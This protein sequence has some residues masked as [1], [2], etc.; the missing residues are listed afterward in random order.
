MS[1]AARDALKAALAIAAPGLAAVRGL[2][3]GGSFG[4]GIAD[5]W[6]D[7]DYVA[8][9]ASDDAAGLVDDWV[10][11][12]SAQAPIVHRMQRVFPTSALVNLITADWVRCDLL[13]ETE[14]R[15]TARAQDRL[16][17]VFERDQLYAALPVKTTL[18]PV[19]T[20]ALT[21]AVEEFL[22]VLGLSHLAVHRDDPFTAQWG[23]AL[24]RD[25]MRVFVL[26]LE[27]AAGLSGALTLARELPEARMALL[28]DLPVGGADLAAALDAQEELA[29]R[30][31]PLAR[32]ECADYDA[33]WPS[34]FVSAT[35]QVLRGVMSDAFCDW[36]AQQ[37]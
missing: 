12:V 22:R 24:M 14:E 11:L 25:Q 6:S 7:L 34:T 13:I 21:A 5:E 20:D 27:P 2:Y 8:V 17:V 28:R 33:R 19:R 3:L 30:F 1:A 4:R 15:F 23:V 16:A 29:R 37:A 9:A 32:A 26:A 36:L 10:G 31:L 18:P 35:A